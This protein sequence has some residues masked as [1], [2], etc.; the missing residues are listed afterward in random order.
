METFIAAIVGP[1]G[2]LVI[3]VAILYGAYKMVNEKG[4]PIVTKYVENVDANM[5]SLLIEH[6]ADREAFVLAISSITARQERLEITVEDI[7]D[8]VSKLLERKN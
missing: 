7:R 5:K 2:S 4:F 1:F 3:L 8:D 6:K